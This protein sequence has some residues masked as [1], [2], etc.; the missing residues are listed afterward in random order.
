MLEVDGLG[1]RYGDVLA[2]SDLSVRVAEGACLEVL[3]ERGVRPFLRYDY[4]GHNAR[5]TL[6]AAV[7]LTR[8]L[9]V[10]EETFGMRSASTNTR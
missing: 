2:L 5:V 3:V 10:V 4:P 1:K 8:D 6:G 7:F 9:Q